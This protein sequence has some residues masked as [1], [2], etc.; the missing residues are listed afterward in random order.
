ML[1]STTLKHC[2]YVEAMEYFDLE[3]PSDLL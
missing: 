3:K 1:A 2:L